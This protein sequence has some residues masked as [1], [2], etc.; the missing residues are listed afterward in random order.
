[1]QSPAQALGVQ[2]AE[3]GGVTVISKKPGN[4]QQPSKNEVAVTYGPNTSTRKYV[5]HGKD[6]SGDP[7]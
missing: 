4:P 6:L 1:M 2:P 7:Y 3:N 5:I